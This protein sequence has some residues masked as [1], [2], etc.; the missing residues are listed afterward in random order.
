MKTQPPWRTSK[1]HNVSEMRSIQ[2][3]CVRTCCLRCRTLWCYCSM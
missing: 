1:K 3:I 2:L